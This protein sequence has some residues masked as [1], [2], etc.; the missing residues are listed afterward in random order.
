MNTRFAP[1]PTGQ[2]HLG[3][4]AAMVYVWGLAA[5]LGAT[6]HVRIEDHDRQRC[7]PEYTAELR[8][9]LDWFGFVPVNGGRWSQQSEHDDRFQ[10]AL[11]LL[12]ERN[13]VYACRCSRKEL[14]PLPDAAERR[15]PGHCRDLNLPETEG[16]ALR[17]R[18]PADS[19]EFHDARHGRQTQRPSAQCGDPVVRDRLGQWT[20]QFVVV[21]D[22]L[23][24]GIDWVIRGDDLLPSTGR[25][26]LLARLLGRSAPLHYFHH[27]LIVNPDG[28]KLSKRDAAA[29]IAELRGQGLSPAGIIGLAASRCGLLPEPAPRRL[30]DLADL[31]G[32]WTFE[33][34]FHQPYRFVY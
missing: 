20:Y 7:R 33:N 6:V 4:V 17:V 30:D 32:R 11:A 1:S 19:I 9:T 28:T 5:R 3:H 18:L 2:L 27:P 24:D 12:R 23:H 10:S 29:P 21:V 26:L 25:Q 13:L 34:L 15:Y 16:T 14:E 8:E 31:F 22:D